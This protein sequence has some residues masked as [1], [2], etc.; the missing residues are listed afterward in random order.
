LHP[1]D[2]W[3]FAAAYDRMACPLEHAVRGDRRAACSPA[4]DRDILAAG[5]GT[6][7]TVHKREHPGA[8]PRSQQD[9]NLRSLP[10]EGS[11]LSV[12]TIGAECAGMESNHR[13]RGHSFTDC[14]ITALPPTL[15]VTGATRTRSLRDHDPALWPVELQPPYSAK[16]SDLRSAGVG[17]ALSH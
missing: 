6:G 5:A 14:C 9:S 10:S 1:P 17:R 16:D 8:D 4:L 11:V 15:G 7:A 12:W 2:Q 13:C 3:I